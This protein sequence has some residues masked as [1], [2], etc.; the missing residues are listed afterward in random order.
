MRTQVPQDQNP[1]PGA[2][3][4]NLQLQAKRHFHI[5]HTTVYG[6]R[7]GVKSHNV[8]SRGRPVLSPL[9]KWIWH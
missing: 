6:G 4:K 5:K 9:W 3:E 2:R 7:Q 1:L 8:T